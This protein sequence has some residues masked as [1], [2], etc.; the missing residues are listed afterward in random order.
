MLWYGPHAGSNQHLRRKSVI[1]TKPDLF[2]S[3]GVVLIDDGD[4]VIGQQL[5]E[6]IAGIQVRTSITQV[7]H[8][9]QDLRTC[10]QAATRTQ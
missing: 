2:N 4:C 6:G 7:V 5:L 3:N 8:R 10:L 1:V 9:Q